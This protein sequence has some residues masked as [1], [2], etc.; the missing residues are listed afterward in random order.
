MAL[1]VLRRAR[2]VALGDDCLMPRPNRDRVMVSFYLARAGK[3]AIVELA[4]ERGQTQA[5]TLR[6]MLAYA[7]R[8][9][10]KDWQP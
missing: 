9:M 2:S 7:Q 6:A 5:D 1:P 8:H 3:A 10:P 4:A